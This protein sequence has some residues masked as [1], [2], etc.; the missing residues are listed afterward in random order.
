MQKNETVIKKINCERI[1]L[2]LLAAARQG[3]VRGGTRG[4]A[5][6]GISPKGSI[7]S[8]VKEK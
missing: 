3:E 8:D 1:Q 6:A 5:D 7:I 2:G 4:V